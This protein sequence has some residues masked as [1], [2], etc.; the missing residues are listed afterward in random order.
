MGRNVQRQ[1]AL[2][3]VYN[4]VKLDAGYRIDLVIDGRVLIEVKSVDIL[5]PIHDAQVLT[6]LKL[7]GIRLGFL[8]NFNE[9]LVKDGLKRLVM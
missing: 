3:I 5:A 2:P 7:S 4:D 9:I 6:Y 1:R 8:I